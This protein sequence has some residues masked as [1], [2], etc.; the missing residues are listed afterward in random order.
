MILQ[1]LVENSVKHGISSKI[2]GGEVLIKVEEQEGKTYFIVSDTGKGV[3]DKSVLFANTGV[4]LS[5][6]R[7][8]IEKIYGSELKVSDN[9]PT[10]LKIEFA[11]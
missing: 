5:N 6:T 10:G 7:D 8:R 9:Q 11:I 3:E 2:E 4:G 1:P